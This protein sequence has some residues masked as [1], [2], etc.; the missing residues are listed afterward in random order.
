[1]GVSDRWHFDW[2]SEGLAQLERE[3]GVLGRLGRAGSV[4]VAALAESRPTPP[5][6]RLAELIG[7][8]RVQID[9]YDRHPKDAAAKVLDLNDVGA[10]GD[11]RYDVV[12]LF[13]ASYFIADAERFLV[14]LS[15]VLRPGGLAVI[16]WLHGL[17]N[18]PVLDLPGNPTYGGEVVQFRTTYADARFLA[19][20][21]A[22]FAAFIRHVNRPPWW[23]DLDRPR[24]RRT[25]VEGA[26][27]GLTRA[28]RRRASASPELTLD[29]YL[30]TLDA[31]LA[32]AGKRLIGAPTLEPH[33]KVLFR[34]ARYFYPHVKKF[35]L[36]LL[37]VL[38]PISK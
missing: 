20:F 34:H 16:D 31:A 24:R 10:L 36:Y 1:L 6:A 25:I 29:T 3:H 5:L 23:V 22:E 15:R 19:E 12:T 2:L 35:N 27:R 9:L 26:W 30:A 17:S 11:N 18:A 21:P 37:T 32:R 8:E 38:T 33:F 28:G 14:D 4:S 13:R 7:R